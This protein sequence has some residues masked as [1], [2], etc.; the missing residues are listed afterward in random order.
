MAQDC[1]Y[2]CGL[3][4]QCGGQ[5]AD[6][7]TDQQ[8]A[9]DFFCERYTS[10]CQPD[11]GITIPTTLPE[12]TELWDNI[13]FLVLFV[14][15][16]SQLNLT[17]INEDT[18]MKMDIFIDQ[19]VSEFRGMTDLGT[20]VRIVVF[21]TPFDDG[22]VLTNKFIASVESDA[23]IG[24]FPVVSIEVIKMLTNFAVRLSI[25]YIAYMIWL[26]MLN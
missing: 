9:N 19:I 10:T 11:F 25:G 7:A 13:Q 14:D 21:L 23:D 16:Q 17:M 2:D 4:N 5:G 1:T 24:D 6:C 18:A 3:D 12:Y 8:C 20:Y 26:I 22:E 15:P